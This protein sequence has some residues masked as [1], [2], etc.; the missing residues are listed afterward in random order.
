MLSSACEAI[1]SGAFSSIESV[2][3]MKQAGLHA[4]IEQKQAIWRAALLLCIAS[5]AL[6]HS[7][8]S[9]I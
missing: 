1:L 7:F 8:A 3:S 4:L 6:P 9:V 5:G 2:V